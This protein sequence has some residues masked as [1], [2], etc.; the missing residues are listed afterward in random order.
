MVNPSDIDISNGLV[1]SALGNSEKETI[2]CNII[3]LCRERGD[4]WQTFSWS[5]YRHYCKHEVTG[6][7]RVVLDGFVKDKLLSFDDGLYKVED[8]FIAT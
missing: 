8:A 5:D 1:G 6:E 7:E 3:F 4:A 2:A